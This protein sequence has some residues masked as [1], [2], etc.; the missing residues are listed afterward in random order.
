[1]LVDVFPGLN[2][3]AFRMHEKSPLY[4]LFFSN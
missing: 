1:M 2:V 3:G 4:V